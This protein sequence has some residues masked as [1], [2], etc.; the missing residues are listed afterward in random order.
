[1]S[2]IVPSL[3][4]ADFY[5]LNREAFNY[6]A[7]AF[8][9]KMS[10]G[11]FVFGL[12][13]LQDL[14]PKLQESMAKSFSGGYL[15]KKFGWDNLLSDLETLGG[16]VQTA[17]DRLE[18]LKRI[19]GVPTRLGF[20]RPNLDVLTHH[21]GE[22]V[23][24]SIEDA[25][26]HTTITLKSCRMDMRA[27]ATIVETLDFLDGT[28]GLIRS[29]TGALGL[30]NPVKAIWETLPFSF[31]VDWFFN[32]SGHLDTVTRAEPATGWNVSNVSCSY[33]LTAEF[34]IAST[35][36]QGFDLTTGYTR[37][38]GV[39]RLDEYRRFAELPLSV[40][41]LLPTT[42]LSPTQLTLLFALLHQAG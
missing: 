40:V 42:E 36:V 20:S 31:L 3:S 41:D 26:I 18:Y 34:S 1:L 24:C 13:E 2:S 23:D 8:P 32:I 11:E 10:F 9:Q 7:D 14:I 16:I 21:V 25:A 5:G 15:N 27:T 33:H 35:R 37:D 19:Y 29:L 4:D 38:Q 28:I 12:R 6:F 30:N 22:H 17:R 39:I